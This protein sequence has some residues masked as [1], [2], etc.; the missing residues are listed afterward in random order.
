VS[1]SRAPADRILLVLVA[2]G[3]LL[4]G[5]AGLVYEVLWGRYLG[6]FIGGT[7]QAH[8]LVLATFMGGLA[9]GNAIFGRIVDRVADRLLFYAILE[10]GIGA[11]CFFFPEIFEGL[12]AL[13]LELARLNGAGS[14]INGPLKAMLA[15]ACMLPPTV[16]M[17]GTLPALARATTQ[18]LAD[19]GPQVA[20]LYFVNSLGA[21]AGAA[22]AG[23]WVLEALGLAAG[24]RAAATVNLALAG[25]FWLASR[26]GLAAMKSTTAP[27]GESPAGPATQV[28]APAGR[29]MRAVLLIICLSGGISMIYELAWVRMLSLVLGSSTY[30][31]ALMLTLFITGIAVGSAF[32]ERLLRRGVDPYR[33]LMWAELGVFLAV[34]L[35]L[36]LYNRLPWTFHWLATAIERAPRAF[37]LYLGLKVA[38]AGGLLVIPTLFIGATLPFATAACVDDLSRLG[39]KIGT[40]FSLNTVGTIGGASLAG[41]VILPSVGVGG[42]LQ[43]GIAASAACGLALLMADGRPWRRGLKPALG[44]SVPALFLV[45]AMATPPLDLGMLHSGI[46]R[47]R[48]PVADSFEEA[49][50]KLGNVEMLFHADGSNAS[51]VVL[52]DRA[53]GHRYLK[54]NGKTEASSEFDMSTQYWLGHLGLLLHPQAT[55]RRVAHIGLASGVSAAASLRWPE[56]TLDLIEIES[57]MLDAAR[58]FADINDDALDH[59]R[60]R[61]HLMDARE[62]FQLAPP[63]SFD[64]IVSEP[65]NPWVAGIGNLFTERF[66]ETMR[67]RLADDGLV[68]QWL[69]TYEMDD[70]IASMV[71]NTFT[72]VFPHATAWRSGPSDVLLIGGKQ[73]L[74]PD[75]NLLARKLA[76]PELAA[77]LRNQK[78]GMNVTD[79]LDV[80]ALQILSEGWLKLHF[81]GHGPLN[82]D[83]RPLLELWAP[84]AFFVGKNTQIFDHLDEKLRPKSQSGL[85]LAAALRTPVPEARIDALVK[86]GRDARSRP[87]ETVVD[88]ALRVSVQEARLAA[89]GTATDANTASL[90]MRLQRAGDPAHQR[91]A[92]IYRQQH[93]SGDL[94][95][96]AVLKVAR[97]EALRLRRLVSVFHQPDPA[98]LVALTGPAAATV[99]GDLR[100]TARL[101]ATLARTWLDLGDLQRAAHATAEIVRLIKDGDEVVASLPVKDPWRRLPATTRGRLDGLAAYL[102][103]R[104]ALARGDG[105]AAAKALAGLLQRDAEHVAARAHLGALVGTGPDR[106]DGKPD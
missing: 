90:E 65:S 88:R 54:S 45:V 14:P 57:G 11:F 27:A 64:V 102:Q 103:A 68:V 51:V 10:V 83:D 28:A 26:S 71:V 6:L 3:F 70:A 47:R 75:A 52:R 43:V 67:S 58:H 73:P 39:R 31:F 38:T 42:A 62:F 96:S 97:F 74:R 40:I 105:Q 63:G 7:A 36:P 29:R 78:A 9:L 44:I 61:I 84:R 37:G 89:H 69:H 80:L 2:A 99:A 79:V 76:R 15:A 48:E 53:S 32:A 34:L 104:L 106:A 33:A 8:T 12:S 91:R 59:E 24:M 81:P 18:R 19:A 82:S 30:S 77:H 22:L 92:A 21:A 13:Y 101:Q 93:A 85:L 66:F 95:K 35:M 72:R 16:L 49:R 87:G 86:A 25:V 94:P 23:F 1:R 50:K 20:R 46:Y 4:S 17:G 60:L 41:L 5:L 55:P 56:V 100:Q 98:F